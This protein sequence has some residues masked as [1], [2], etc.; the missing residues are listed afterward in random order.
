MNPPLSGEQVRAFHRDG[1]LIVLLDAEEAKLLE[2]AARADQRMQEA[3]MRVADRTGRATQLSLWNHPGDDIYGAIARSR[4]VVDAMEEL[5]GDEVY[6]YHSK[7]KNGCLWPDM[8][9]VMIAIDPA[10]RA[11]GCL[12]VM[13]GSHLL[14][15]IDHGRYGEQTG[16]DPERVAL[17]RERLGVV[18]CEMAPGDGLFFHA[19][20]LHASAANTSDS[21]RWALLCCY[22]A[23]TNDPVKE[24]HHPRY[25]PLAKLPDTAIKAM[26]AK[27]TAAG[28][29]F[30]H[31]EDDE[32][33]G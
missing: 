10:T 14:G 29:A 6:H 1:Y 19:N 26:G 25:T 9:S 17:I 33:T 30:L 31:Q 20:L 24:H 8:A 2:T 4:R 28:Q 32:T 16:A 15:R 11:N 7:L 12:Q 13:P 27:P 23:A 21:P 5:L 3:A 22:N 18:F